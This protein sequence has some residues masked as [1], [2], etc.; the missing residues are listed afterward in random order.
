M[1]NGKYIFSEK[2]L[3]GAAL[4]LIKCREQIKL[5]LTCEHISELLSNI[6]TKMSNV[7]YS[8]GKYVINLAY[9]SLFFFF[10][11]ESWYAY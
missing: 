5:L 9:F 8:F 10:V 3:F 11:L 6:S 1:H 4:D 2:K 7:Y